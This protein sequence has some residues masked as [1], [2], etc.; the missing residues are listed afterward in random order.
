[1]YT[2]TMPRVIID[3]YQSLMVMVRNSA[4]GDNHMFRTVIATVDG[5][6][7]DI[8]RDGA[9]SC[10]FFVSSILYI[11]KLIRDMHTGVAGLERDMAASGWVQ[12]PEL[13]EGAVIIWEPKEGS[14]GV[15]HLHTG[16]YVGNN[17]AISNGSNTSHIPEEHHVTYEGTREIGRMW[18]HQS[19]DH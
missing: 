17:R 1:M 4:K 18:W 3:T 2:S 15:L 12:I 7:T 6:T 11:N 9:L 10:G 8:L 19:L 14:G 5:E 13:R 16:F